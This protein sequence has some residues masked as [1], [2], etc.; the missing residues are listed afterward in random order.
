MSAQ[1]FCKSSA[2]VSPAADADHKKTLL[3]APHI[4]A[5]ILPRSA[6]QLASTM[7]R[8]TIRNIFFPNN[9]APADAAQPPAAGGESDA[10]ARALEIAGYPTLLQE[11]LWQQQQQQQQDRVTAAANAAA[12][13]SRLSMASGLGDQW[14][15]HGLSS[16][17][18]MRA[19]S[20]GAG[21]FASV[22][23]VPSSMGGLGAGGMD[24][25][26]QQ[27]NFNFGTDP[28]QLLLS[29][30]Q[31]SQGMSAANQGMP[32]GVWGGAQGDPT[33]GL[34]A[35]DR[36]AE[37]G[38]LAP[39]SERSAGLLG[40]MVATGA[41]VKPA[42]VKK[43][44]RKQPKD[45]PKRPLSAYNNFFKE[46][47]A[48]LLAKLDEANNTDQGEEGQDEATERKPPSKIGFENLAK[49][50]GSKWQS[51]VPKDVEYYKEKAG[52]DMKRYKTEMEGYLAKQAI[53]DSKE[54]GIEE[55]EEDKETSKPA[56]KKRK[57]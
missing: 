8:A 26:S 38:I 41:P 21:S 39:W 24:S 33:S 28:N 3:T 37:N 27:Q 47:R 5:A 13:E 10:A 44:R 50:I 49:M 17:N 11:Y 4:P 16:R 6:Q 7:D 43:G 56:A 22:Y 54:A 40:S 53:K 18:M 15:G 25:I 20:Q 32:S 14:G 19:A 46:E 12:I 31:A 57:I 55:T 42:K 45:K 52:E 23:G 30:L 36:F 29:H 51:L 34:S 48:R 2:K 35:V 1:K 9:G